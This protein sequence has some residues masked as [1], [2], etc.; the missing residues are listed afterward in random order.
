MYPPS[1]LLLPALLAAVLTCTIA[2]EPLHR[3]VPAFSDEDAGSDTDLPDSDED[4][5]SDADLP[6]SDE[7]AGSDADLPDATQPPAQDW[8]VEEYEDGVSDHGSGS[9]Y[10]ATVALGW[11]PQVGNTLIAI[12]AHRMSWDEAEMVNSGWNEAL[13]LVSTPGNNSHRRGLAM[14]YRIIEDDEPDEVTI[15]WRDRGDLTD[16]DRA[17]LVQVFE[18]EGQWSLDTVS[19]ATSPNTSVNTVTTGVTDVASDSPSL[20]VVTQMTR[21]D[22]GVADWTNGFETGEYFFYQE[23]DISGLTM[24]TGGLVSSDQQAWESMASWG[25]ATGSAIGAIAVFKL[26]SEAGL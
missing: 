18:V 10:T 16:G 20:V 22:G 21:G 17:H 14:W 4:A 13:E 9:G 23:E 7:D 5:G 26:L 6:D 2:C 8:P 11:T 12:S 25:D 19:A 15:T 3:D 24:N 1:R